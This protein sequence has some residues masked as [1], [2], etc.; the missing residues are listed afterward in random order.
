MSQ[1]AHDSIHPGPYI[2]GYVLPPDMSVTEAAKKLGVSRPTL[3]NLLNTRIALSQG[4]AARLENTFGADGNDL[5]RRQAQ[6]DA[7]KQRDDQAESGG[8]AYIHGLSA[9]TA[10]QIEEWA[11]GNRQARSLLAVLLRRL[12]HS[13]GRDLTEVDF[14][15]Y[16]NAER[17]GWD[18]TTVAGAATAWIPEG[19]ACWEFSVTHNP[20]RKAG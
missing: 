14:P 15:G 20:G 7:G 18:G 1:E 11:T 9:I 2:K 12:V 13:T 3:S 16:D 5:L 10:R 6:Y 17:K 4:M 19:K 8:R